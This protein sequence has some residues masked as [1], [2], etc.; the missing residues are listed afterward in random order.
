MSFPFSQNRNSLI[1]VCK[2]EHQLLL[3]Q[4]S[5]GW[6]HFGVRATASSALKKHATKNKVAPNLLPGKSQISRFGRLFL[7]RKLP[8]PPKAVTGVTGVTRISKDKYSISANSAGADWQWYTCPRRQSCALGQAV[9]MQKFPL[10]RGLRALKLED[11]SEPSGPVVY[12]SICDL[13]LQ[14]YLTGANNKPGQTRFY[15]GELLLWSVGR[16]VATVPLIESSFGGGP[17]KPSSRSRTIC[18]HLFWRR[19]P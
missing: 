17:R 10:D 9:E 19:Q 3:C 2:P 6:H 5:C 11:C 8:D 16:I 4:Q 15:R 13:S 14:W 18:Q 1:S 12:A 7:R